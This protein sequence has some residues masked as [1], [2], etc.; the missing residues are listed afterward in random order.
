LVAVTD[1]VAMDQI[2]VEER[3]AT[4]ARDTAEAAQRALQW[5]NDEANAGSVGQ[6]QKALNREFRRFATGARK[7]EQAVARPMCV[8]VFGPSQAG[9]SYLVS[10]LARPGEKPLIADFDGQGIDFIA[11][12]NPEGGKE[13]TGLVTRFSLT[14]QQHPPGFP[15]CLRLLSEADVIKIIANTF[16]LD[17]DL[18]EEAVPSPEDIDAA[19]RAARAAAGSQV[20]GLSE[21]EVYDIQEYVEKHFRGSEQARALQAF[22]EEAAQLA[23]KLRPEDR[24]ALL[25]I[26]WGGHEPFTRLYRLLAEALA[27][28]GHPADAF[29]P[30]DALIPRDNSIIDVATLGGL[31]AAG[32]SML[33]ISPPSGAPVELPRPVVTAITAELRIVMRE[34][35]RPFFEHTDLLDFPGA[36][37]RQPL[38]LGRYFAQNDNALKETFLRGKV[39]Y[40]FDR[41]VAEQELTSMLLCIG[42]GNQEVTTLPNMIAEWIATTHGA[43]PD[44]RAKRRCVFFL[45]LTMFDM[46]FGEKAGSTD[47]DPGNRFATR[48]EASLLGFF[49]KAH[50][51]PREWA[52]AQPFTN[53]VWLRNPNFKAET[54]IEYA[55]G[56]EKA[57]RA[58][59]EQRIAELRAGYLGVPEVRAHFKEPE[60]AF[61]EALRLND[62]G[63]DYLAGLL[64]PMCEP[65]IKYQQ[66]DERLSKVRRDMLERVK[67]FHVS[68]DVE[69]RLQERRQVAHRVVDG[70][71]EAADYGRFGAVLESLQIEPGALGDAMYRA[72]NQPDANVRIVAAPVHAGGI[73]R[74]RPRPRPGMAAAGNGGTPAAVARDDR[75]Q[76]LTRPQFLADVALRHW[77]GQLRAAAEAD[78]LEHRLK[79]PAIDFGELT[80]ELM[81]GIRRL[82]LGARVARAIADASYIDKG[83]TAVA[84][85][86]LLACRMING[87]VSYLGFD[88]LPPDQRPKVETGEGES[89]PVFRPRPIAHDAR[90]IGAEPVPFGED[91]VADWV[92]A[93][94]RLVEENASSQ[95]GL[96]VDIEQNARI[97]AVVKALA[98]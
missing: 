54:I 23:T 27:R 94:F 55:G 15:V 76:A 20:P 41:Y 75:P 82:G 73:D 5:F 8:G 18:T 50:D 80:A 96:K 85:P 16:F 44:E 14:R 51:W 9:K 19:L 22:W 81:A 34:P 84:R 11:E 98:A 62:G 3:L 77:I 4:R 60:R 68:D 97:G 72:E 37:S 67:R 92:F 52:P 93:F 36:R 69:I 89:R 17:G 56:L 74:P 28:L 87:Y 39:A 1:E 25:A 45:V 95:D 90:A 35:P 64:E 12:I 38:S 70:L 31:G 33:K 40:L 65:G 49:G 57:I 58:D 83:E 78:D 53:C 43:T 13:S 71:Y 46:M 48:M 47:A 30:L 32:G 66:L 2:A 63:I 59:K 29:A 21:D 88:G 6:E 42:Y 86:A 26:L 7:L 24:G 61:D 10:V 79:V 91:F